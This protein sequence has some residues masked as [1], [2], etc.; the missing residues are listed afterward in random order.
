MTKQQ[1][2]AC[3]KALARQHA[4]DAVVVNIGDDWQVQ[5]YDEWRITRSTRYDARV[6]ASGDIE[7]P[8]AYAPIEI[9]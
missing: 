9:P 6:T 1:A 3:A 4:A 5:L 7:Y 2:I 8:K